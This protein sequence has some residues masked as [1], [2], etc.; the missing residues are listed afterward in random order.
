M[1]AFLDNCKFTPAAGGTTD[2]TVSAAVTGYQSPSAAGVVNSEKYKYFAVSADL[3]QWEI[4]EGAYNTSTNV[5]PRTTILYNSSG[6]GTATGQSGAGTKINFTS[7]PS[8]SVIAIKEDLLALDEANSFTPTQQNQA[9][10]NLGIPSILQGYIAGLTLSTA[11]SSAT[12]SVSSGVAVDSSAAD[13]ISLASSMSKTTSAW[14]SGSGNGGLDTGSIAA[15]TWYHAYLIKNVITQAVDV[16]VSLSASSPT[17]PSGYTLFRRIGSMKT[18][19]SNHWTA[20]VQVGNKFYWST[21]PAIDVNTT[22]LGLTATTFT[23]TNI[24]TGVSVEAILNTEIGNAAGGASIYIYSP[25]VNDQAASSGAAPISQM[26]C[27]NNS[28]GFVANSNIRIMTNTSAQIKAVGDT[29][30]TIFR[31]A[32]TGWTDTRGGGLSV[33]GAALLA[34]QY[35]GTATNDNAAAGNIGEYV[36]SS[37]AS[38]SAVSLTANTAANMTSI[39]I[40][41]GDWEIELSGYIGGGSTTTVTRAEMSISTTSATENTTP[42]AIAYWSAGTTGLTPFNNNPLYFHATERLSIN[43]TTTVFAVALANFSASTCNTYG[44]LRARRAR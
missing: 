42:G 18:D 40:T 8:V 9:Q 6:T 2:W 32:V 37:V 7:A 43:V 28:A 14:A 19:G 39:A 22:T 11:G 31:V 23:L 30:S 12:F 1:A 35:P 10:R 20:F 34:G 44:I 33:A 3:T 41:P 17:L 26:I 16:L 38:G 24:P 27:T 4:G 15:S 13:S 36:S 5:L 29:A 21:V 25:L